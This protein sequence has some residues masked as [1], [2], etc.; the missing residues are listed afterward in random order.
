MP[1]LR[2]GDILSPSLKALP[3]QFATKFHEELF[4]AAVLSQAAAELNRR[5]LINTRT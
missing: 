4:S 2:I 5:F 1:P 3:I